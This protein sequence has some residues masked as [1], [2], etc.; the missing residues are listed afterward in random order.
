MKA[1]TSNNNSEEPKRKE[2]RSFSDQPHVVEGLKNMQSSSIYIVSLIV[3][4]FS[5]HLDKNGS[6]ARGWKQTKDCYLDTSV[7]LDK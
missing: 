2:S 1:N 4:F 3:A 5:Y 6:F 7:Y